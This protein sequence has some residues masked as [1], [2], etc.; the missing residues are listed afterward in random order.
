MREEDSLKT[1]FLRALIK[2]IKK[3]KDKFSGRNGGDKK[4]IYII[5]VCLLLFKNLLAPIAAI[6]APGLLIKGLFSRITSGK[7][8]KKEI[9]IEVF[10]QDVKES[11]IYLKIKENY[12]EYN[13]DINE[14]V[15][16]KIKE[17]EGKYTYTKTIKKSVPKLDKKGNVKYNKKGEI[18]MVTIEE[19][20]T[21]VPEIIKSVDLQKPEIQLVMAYIST[22]YLAFEEV[23]D[24]YK[25][26]SEEVK[27]FLDNITMNY[28]NVRIISEDEDGLPK[29][30]RYISYN[31][32]KAT[33]QIAIQ[34]FTKEEY[35][36][37]YS[38]VRDAYITS[39]ESYQDIDD[40]E[41][42]HSYQDIDISNITIHASGM[43]IPHYLQYDSKWGKEPYGTGTI[44]RCGCGPTCIAMIFSY[45]KGT[46]ITPSE[47]ANWATT[48]EK[49]RYY[50]P[51]AGSIWSIFSEAANTYNLECRNIGKN[52]ITM[53]NSLMQGYPV[54]CSMK[55]GTF[56]KGGHFIVLRGITEDGKILV[57]DPN[58]NI[59][60]K[61]F[62]SKE[63][64]PNLILSESKCMW[65]IYK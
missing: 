6:S 26:D 49:Y 62:Y 24:N 59:Y 45:L 46:V 2:V 8:E 22:K 16:K 18:I 65:I 32:V 58:D 15:E 21:I 52:M 11:E 25:Y 20:N 30:I 12:I 48:P 57:N 14:M 51:N 44:A 19:T 36:D 10:D 34:Y 37:D 35:P 50:D 40:E 38:E 56:T 41:V 47:I 53:M 55:P 43:K 1:A 5:I 63:F 39:Y 29:K 7:E 28:E 3:A 4:K 42:V 31:T 33:E 17:L 64:S 61:N 9:D 60:S 27:E 23:D 54:I 13:N